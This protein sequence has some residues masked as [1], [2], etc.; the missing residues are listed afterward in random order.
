M[1]D[2]LMMHAGGSRVERQELALIPTPEPTRSWRPVPHLKVAELVIAETM[3]RGYMIK[4]ESY[5]LSNDKLMMFGVLKFALMDRPDMTRCLGFRN[6]HN[7][8]LALG[9]TA[10]VNVLVCDNLA[11]GGEVTLQRKHTSCL[12]AETLIPESFEQLNRQFMRLEENIDVMKTQAITLDEARIVTCVAAERKVIPSC[13]IIQVIDT[14]KEPPHEEFKEPTKWN[15]HNAFT[16][17][18]KKY[19][20]TRFDQ[21]QKGLADLFRLN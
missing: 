2:G 4:A 12:D 6:S 13:D 16:E 15:L 8:K 14:F 20:P 7:K 5:G 11:F 1:S 10:G 3:R 9:L 17:V 18:A 19:T 21:C